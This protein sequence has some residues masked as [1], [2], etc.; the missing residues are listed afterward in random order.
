MAVPAGPPLSF[1]RKGRLM[2]FA[3]IGLRAGSPPAR[4]IDPNSVN[5]AAGFM[6]LETLTALTILAIA[7]VS[8]FEARARAL[9]NVRVATDYANARILGQA[10]LADTVSGYNGH[11]ISRTGSDGRF[12]WS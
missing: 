2:K 7:F 4:S 1:A 8:L 3:S 11:V 5:S 6:L 9:Q 12:D 10:L